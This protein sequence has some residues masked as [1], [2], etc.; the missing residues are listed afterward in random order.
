MKTAMEMR[1][2]KEIKKAFESEGFKFKSISQVADIV[3]QNDTASEN[4]YAQVRLAMNAMKAEGVIEFEKTKRGRPEIRQK[5]EILTSKQVMDKYGIKGN[6]VTKTAEAKL[7]ADGYVK[8]KADSFPF[9][10]TYV[11]KG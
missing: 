10:V 5:T 4:V 8:T 7:A 1:Y 6:K 2:A 3:K 9:A 11:K